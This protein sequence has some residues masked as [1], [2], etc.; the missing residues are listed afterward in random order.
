VNLKCISNKWNNFA[1]RHCAWQKW[2]Q[3]QQQQAAAV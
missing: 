2:W 3:R 1:D